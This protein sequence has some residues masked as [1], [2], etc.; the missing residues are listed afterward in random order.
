MGLNEDVSEMC[1]ILES[2]LQRRWDGKECIL[3]LKD[4][5]YQWKQME[6]V[7]WYFEWKAFNIL[8]KKLGGT[9]GPKYGN[10]RFD[11]LRNQRVWD[12]KAHITNASS[13]PWAILNDCEGV[14][15]C[16]DEFKGLGFII[17]RGEATYD[18]DGTLKDWHDRL[19][20][21]KS[22][23]ERERI[24]RGAPSRRR[25]T[26]LNV[27]KFQIIYMTKSI[28]Q[29]GLERNWLKYFQRGMRNADGSSRRAKYRINVDMAPANAVIGCQSDI[30]QE[31]LY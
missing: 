13:H 2:E 1:K 7:G 5:D 9:I 26:S 18:D 11:Y 14:D 24:R 4:A 17:A 6:W 29:D 19:K 15:N 21:K 22:A 25:K 31:P 28:L 20:G 10:M 27:E 12:F 30:F 16:I 8:S 3:E 23:Y